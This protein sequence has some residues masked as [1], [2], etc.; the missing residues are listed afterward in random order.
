MKFNLGGLEYGAAIGG[1][2]QVPARSTM[3]AS[4]RGTAR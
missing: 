2:A 4:A 1:P 3:V